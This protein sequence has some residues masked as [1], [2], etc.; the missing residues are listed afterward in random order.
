M[1][2]DRNISKAPTDKWETGLFAKETGDD[3]RKKNQRVR[4]V[5]IQVTVN[6]T[7]METKWAID[8]NI[9]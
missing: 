3:K 2:I 5:E 4:C 8:R 7:N 9:K 6:Y 1:Y